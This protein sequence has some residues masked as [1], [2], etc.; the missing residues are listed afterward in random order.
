MRKNN[1]ESSGFGLILAIICLFFVILG[2]FGYSTL[3]EINKKK[4]VE[5]NIDLLKKEAQK[6]EKE[7]MELEERLA[8]LG[9]NDYKELQAKSKL[10]LQNPNEDVIIIT[11]ETI[12]KKEE[13]PQEI[14]NQI[15]QSKEIPNYQKWWK[16]F[17][18]K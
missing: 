1:K 10:N 3:K 11:Q 2:F 16:F 18:D 17:F 13:K 4:Q 15:F 9:S 6:I 8:Y 5:S 12:Q 7:N 14:S